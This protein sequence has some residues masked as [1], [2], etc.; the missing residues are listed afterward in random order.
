VPWYG[1]AGSAIVM[2][3][4]I[5]PQ[6]DYWL[7]IGG[8]WDTPSDWSTGVPGPSNDVVISTEYVDPEVTARLGTVNSITITTEA[9][10]LF[11]GASSVT[12]G[13][14]NSGILDLDARSNYNDPGGSL[15]KIKGVL[16]NSGGVAIGNSTLSAASTIQA[17]TVVNR[18]TISLSGCGTSTRL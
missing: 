14:S 10:L 6:K 15:L 17:A 16:T 18:G 3:K 4:T 11:I 5:V 9:P 8:C 7:G 13:V 12:G 1:D 2:A